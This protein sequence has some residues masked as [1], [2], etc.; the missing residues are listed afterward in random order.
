MFQ[1]DVRN[2]C[3]LSMSSPTCEFFDRVG[4]GTSG[5]AQLN[6][7]SIAM[8]QGMQGM[9]RRVLGPPIAHN[10]AVFQ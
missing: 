2:I 7:G 6:P 5:A 9:G 4:I 10:A 3:V 1:A 8:K